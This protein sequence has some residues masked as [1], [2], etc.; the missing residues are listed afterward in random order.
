MKRIETIGGTAGKE[1]ATPAEREYI[2]LEEPGCF[3]F[4][5]SEAGVTLG[6]SGMNS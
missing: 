4:H 6:D 2:F 3:A 5:C 1:K